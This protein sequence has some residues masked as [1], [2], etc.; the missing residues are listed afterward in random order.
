MP[1]AYQRQLSMPSLRGWLI[2]T[3]TSLRATGWRPSVADLGGGM[4]VVL[5]RG[6]N[7]PLLWAMDGT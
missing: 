2:G 7:F 1:L 4:S 3:G 6:S 5:H